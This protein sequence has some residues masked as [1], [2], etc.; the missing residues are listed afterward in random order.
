VYEHPAVLECAVFGMPDERLGE[1]VA[2]AFVA[3]PGFEG[4]RGVDPLEFQSFCRGKMAKFKVPVEIFVWE[5]QLPRGPTGKIPKKDIRR[6]LQDGTAPA[7][8]IAS[9]QQ[10]QAKL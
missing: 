7:V 10:P 9:H 5:G 1:V 4:G 3:K 6:L 8:K 2:V